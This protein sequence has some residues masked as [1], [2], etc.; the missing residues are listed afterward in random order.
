MGPPTLDP[1]DLPLPPRELGR[2]LQRP[3]TGG[4]DRTEIRHLEASIRLGRRHHLAPAE[5]VDSRDLSQTGWGVVLAEDA[6]PAILEALAPLLE[7]RERQ[8]GGGYRQLT[9][10][11]G[12]RAKESKLRFLARHGAASGPVS[13]GLPYYLLLVGSPEAIPFEMQYQID[14]S[15]AVGRLYFEDLADYRRYA[16]TVVATEEG[17]REREPRVE[18]FSVQ[19]PAS[20]PRDKTLERMHRFLTQPLATRLRQECAGW[21]VAESV[22]PASTRESFGRCLGGRTSPALLFASSHGCQY[23]PGDPEQVSGQGALLCADEPGGAFFRG[24]DLGPEAE[25]AGLIAFLFA[26]FS[27]GTPRHNDFF[28]RGG[29]EQVEASPQPFL[30]DLPKRLLTH[31]RGGASALVG[32]VDRAWTYSFSWPGGESQIEVFVSALKRLLNGYPVGAAME[33]LNLRYAELECDLARLRENIEH[34][35]EADLMQLTNLW[36]ARNDA[37]NYIVIGDPAVRLAASPRLPS[38]VEEPR[39][40]G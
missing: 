23:P 12:I 17:A 31:P 38:P 26:C 13:G 34:G 28:H 39:E 40:D 21:E 25:P 1:T 37:R 24:A 33:P 32:H 22:G 11:Q 5:G 4:L 30:A 9:G 2:W 27:A 10:A 36:T 19:P 8:A 6:D 14:V 3:G 20:G 7:L 15:Y 29:R 16:E 35:G 18:V